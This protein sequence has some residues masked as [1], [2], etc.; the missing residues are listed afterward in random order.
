MG[1]KVTLGH[2]LSELVIVLLIVAGLATRCAPVH[3]RTVAVIGGVA[4]VIFGLLTI[5]AERGVSL[6]GS[7]GREE[8]RHASPFFAGFDERR[9]SVFLDLVADGRGCDGDRRPLP[10]DL[11]CLRFHGRGTGVRTSGGSPSSRRAFRGERPSSPIPRTS[12]IMMACGSSFWYL[13]GLLPREGC[14]SHGIGRCPGR[15]CAILTKN[16]N[17]ER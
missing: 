5:T 3:N 11:P 10:G 15:G 8:P 14:F 6:A 16:A 7:G 4:L 1:P 9:E 12:E 13:W 17:K 2:M